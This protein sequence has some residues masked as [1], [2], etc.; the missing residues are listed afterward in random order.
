MPHSPS[1]LA[2]L[3]LS[4]GAALPPSD[5]RSGDPPAAETVEASALATEEQAQGVYGLVPPDRSWRSI[6]PA[7]VRAEV[8]DAICGLAGPG[9][10]RCAMSL[11]EDMRAD[12]EVAVRELL[13]A[14]R[15]DLEDLEFLEPIEVQGLRGAHGLVTGK[16]NQTWWRYYALVFRRGKQLYSLVC[17]GRSEEV[18]ADGSTLQEAVKG[19]RL[20]AADGG[21]N[22]DQLAP[23]ADG[24]GWRVRGGRYQDAAKGFELAP[25]GGW[26]V[27]LG[28]ELAP[29]VVDVDAGLVDEAYDAYIGVRVE[30][31]PGVS[32]EPFLE[33]RR[34]EAGKLGHA[35]G[36]K[37]ARIAGRDVSMELSTS[38]LY[39]D[40]GSLSLRWAHAAFLE[41]E[42]CVQ[43]YV[44]YP[45]S[46]EAAVEQTLPD[47][48]GALK[49]LSEAQ[50]QA[51]E[52]ELRA[53]R[54]RPE[55][56]GAGWVLRDEAYVNFP[57]GVRW[58]LPR[59]WWRVLPSERADASHSGTI[60]E[61][62]ERSL[63]V[64]GWLS[65]APAV[66]G[67]A[68][69][70]RH[71]LE[72]DR[73]LSGRPP[74]S[75]VT[76]VELRL[77]ESP[78]LV[79][80][81][82]VEGGATPVRA[83]LATSVV[84]RRAFVAR[85][86]GVPAVLER[87]E[88]ALLAALDGLALAPRPIPRSE[89]LDGTYRDFRLGFEL[90]S[91]TPGWLFKERRIEHFGP[92]S[93]P[94]QGALVGFEAAPGRGLYAAAVWS[95]DPPEGIDGPLARMLPSSIAKEMG[96]P[97]AAPSGDV[98]ATFRGRSG[99]LL[100]WRL[101]GRSVELLLLRD[102]A[103]VFVVCAAGE[104]GDPPARDSLARFRILD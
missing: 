25:R 72:I 26:R 82:D 71:A 35:T 65:V 4:A 27:A 101:G 45:R 62:R 61:L 63:G 79:S 19:L 49:L 75:T 36:S 85:L 88:E 91:P 102:R 53:A 77:G 59:G 55:V 39:V 5:L 100:S 81:V 30:R 94:A 70:N 32:P 97:D 47:A 40:G 20:R 23:D 3:A 46:A 38:S 50:R 11:A 31:V 64:R 73:A 74:R 98:A 8:P 95:L 87:S 34:F 60:L 96:L 103:T 1:L 84:G 89:V 16:R 99:R 80:L 58:R 104:P 51:L 56:L 57:L 33:A 68:L 41:D 92:D 37:P 67:E 83:L 93:H 48:L 24:V 7:D 78:A 9:S 12:L 29:L 90:S 13:D 76:A 44:R 66:D 42:R 14:R 43:V 6:E 21:I 86:E 17:W 28:G 52:A 54:Y 15:L 69:A 22:A 2:L 18:P 10:V